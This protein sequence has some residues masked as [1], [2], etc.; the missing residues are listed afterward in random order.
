VSKLRAHSRRLE[1]EL[2]RQRLLNRKIKAD[3]LEEIAKL[4]AGQPGS[5][6][7]A[8]GLQSAMGALTALGL[9]SALGDSRRYM[10]SAFEARVDTC[11]TNGP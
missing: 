5:L 6:V 8:T 9:T 10:S 4:A 3:N 2:T 7:S 1:D 11:Q